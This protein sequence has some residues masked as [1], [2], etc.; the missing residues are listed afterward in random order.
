MTA[1]EAERIRALSRAATA[2]TTWMRAEGAA[3]LM[4]DVLGDAF[5]IGCPAGLPKGEVLE[6]VTRVV[7]AT[8]SA[9]ARGGR[10]P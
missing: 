8:R 5:R 4:R 7:A 2:F 6:H 10:T 9:R 3:R 1:A